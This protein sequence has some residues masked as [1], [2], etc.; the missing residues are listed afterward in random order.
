MQTGSVKLTN[1]ASL[2]V[3]ADPITQTPS[4]ILDGLELC[5][6]V[7]SRLSNPEVEWADSRVC[8]RLRMRSLALLQ[9]R[10]FIRANA[11]ARNWNHI[12]TT[13]QWQYW[14]YNDNQKNN[15]NKNEK[16]DNE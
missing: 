3:H 14:Q 16:Q 1:L 12:I 7:L 2:I 10:D 4:P 11:C 13:M 8:V 9:R 15:M 6:H 5:F